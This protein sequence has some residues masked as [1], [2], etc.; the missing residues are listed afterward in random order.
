MSFAGRVAGRPVVTL[1]HGSVSTTYEPVDAF[2]RPGQ[3]VALGELIGTVGTGGHCGDRCL[4]WGLRHGQGYLNPLALLRGRADG[5]VRLVAEAQ[6]DVAR[7]E[8]EQRAAEAAATMV[9]G[10]VGGVSA[11][12]GAVGGH[13]FRAPVAGPVTSPFGMRLHPVLKVWRLHDGT[14]Y[15]APCGTP[16]RAPYAGRVT[17]TG[18]HPAYGN[19]LVLDH[20]RVDGIRV[21]T[22]YNHAAGYVVRPGSRVQAGQL[23]GYVGTTGRSTGCHLHLMVW[24]DGRLVDPLTWF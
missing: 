11:A 10:F 6:R 17:S 9:S 16:I 1:D 4:H 22:A 12:L 20:G 18:P 7:R 8:A 15:G 24:L 14:D 3:R 13:G 23:L 19:R 21:R 2:V 5:R